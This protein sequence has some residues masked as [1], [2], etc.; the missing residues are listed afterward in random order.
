M[1][2][3]VSSAQRGPAAHV[4]S[5]EGKEK[6]PSMGRSST[7]TAQQIRALADLDR[8]S[9]TDLEAMRAT[10]IDTFRKLMIRYVEEA[11]GGGC[12][13]E[14]GSEARPCGRPFEGAARP[15]MAEP[16][17]AASCAARPALW[18]RGWCPPPL[19]E[20]VLAGSGRGSRR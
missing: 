5:C 12:T 8:K 17:R 2:G 13:P 1:I 19:A 7:M 18:G 4:S 20:C 9:D 3:G 10:E 16:A 15:G 11:S 6:N 14:G